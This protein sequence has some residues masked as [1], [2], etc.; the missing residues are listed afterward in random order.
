MGFRRFSLRGKNRC[1][2]EIGPVSLAHNLKKIKNHLKR[3]V[4]QGDGSDT[5][6]YAISTISSGNQTITDSPPALSG[7]RFTAPAFCF[8]LGTLP[9][10]DCR[11]SVMSMF[12]LN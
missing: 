3:L 5:A 2:L 10:N 11:Q 8:Y 4:E 9:R 7:R 6:Q 1:R 12:W